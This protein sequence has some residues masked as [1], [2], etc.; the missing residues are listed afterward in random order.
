[1]SSIWPKSEGEGTERTYFSQGEQHVVQWA[2]GIWCWSRSKKCLVWLL[3]VRKGMKEGIPEM[4]WTRE[5]S[6]RWRNLL[7]ITLS[8]T[9]LKSRAHFQK[10]LPL[11][12]NSHSEALPSPLVSR[13]WE[14]SWGKSLWRVLL[15]DF[16]KGLRED[17]P[18]AIKPASLWMDELLN[19][20]SGAFQQNEGEKSVSAPFSMTN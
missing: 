13:L 19:W 14:G 6:K 2:R 18:G 9:G 3:R 20:P 15:G 8:H 7:W 4:R 16:F 1:M 17:C 10:P 12:N 5:E 11:N